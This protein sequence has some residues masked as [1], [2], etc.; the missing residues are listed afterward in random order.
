[1]SPVN[2]RDAEFGY[3]AGEVDPVKALHPGLVYDADEEDYIKLLCGHGFNTTAALKLITRDNSSCSE[4]T[5]GS[6]RDLNYPSFALKAAHP[7][8]H[9]SGRFHRTVTNV[10]TPFSTYRAIV[11]APRGLHIYVIPSVLSFTSLGEN[12]TYVVI[13]DG[14]L[15][16][17]M[18]SASLTWDD[19]Y[20]NVR[21]PIVIFDERAERVATSSTLRNV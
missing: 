10:G 20:F 19:G 13:V 12:H 1:M 8:Q 6:A 2:N 5:P 16:K 3:G 14:V 17:S 15:K 18:E 21:S 4:I 11:T 9:V 7:K